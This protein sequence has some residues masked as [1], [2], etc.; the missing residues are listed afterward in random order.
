[1]LRADPDLRGYLRGRAFSGRYSAAEGQYHFTKG[2]LEIRFREGVPM[3]LAGPYALRLLVAPV[4]RRGRMELPALE[5]AWLTNNLMRI[6]KRLVTEGAGKP[7]VRPVD[8]RPIVEPIRPTATNAARPPIASATNAEKPPRATATNALKPIAS[9]PRVEIPG[10][11]L[12]LTNT[13]RIDWIFLDPGHGGIDPGAVSY[14][15]LEKDYTLKIS[16]ALREALTNRL[17][18][19]Q[20]LLLREKDEFQSSEDRCRV[21][22]GKLKRDQNGIFVSIHLNIWL[23]AETRGFEVYYMGHQEWSENARIWAIWENRV[24][25][26]DRTNLAG[27][28]DWEK[29]FGRIAAVQYQKESRMIAENVHFAVFNRIKDYAVSRGVKS[30]TFYV[31]KGAVMPSIL[32][33]CGF[34]SNKADMEYLS[35]DEKMHKL[36][37]AIAEGLAQYV[38]DFNQTGG[39]T[40]D[41]F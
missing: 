17:P 9:P 1:M 15:F 28:S 27:L 24:F 37:D 16:K 8:P 41:L 32:I 6:E 35:E 29:I 3:V 25:N 38:K 19:V 12:R 40:G 23:D 7:P 33:E 2:A 13:G 36:V 4:E 21:A 5:F 10:D 39:F 26:P 11:V 14:G 30:E 18:L 31:L 20:T 22:N 34:L